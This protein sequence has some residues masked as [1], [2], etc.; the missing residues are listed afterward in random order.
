MQPLEAFTLKAF[1]VALSQLDAPLPDE[2]QA[3]VNQIRIPADIGKLDAIAR[4]YP[5][6]A[7]P[8]KEV[9]QH[10][11]AIAKERSKGREALPEPEPEE[12]NTEIDNSTREIGEVLVEF[13]KK[14]DDNK[15]TVIARNVFNALNPV[16]SAKAEIIPILLY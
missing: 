3:R 12:L 15:L 1:L 13:D 2:V 4:N 6:L 7:Q 5:P 16:Q 9:R 11:R 10:L 14:V 8:Y